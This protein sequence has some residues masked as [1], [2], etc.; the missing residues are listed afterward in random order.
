MV[1]TEAL[2]PSLQPVGGY[3]LGSWMHARGAPAWAGGLLLASLVKYGAGLIPSWS[4]LQALAI[5]W[6]DPLLSPALQPPEDFRLRTP[7]SA[8]LAGWLH[9]TSPAAFL[10]FHFILACV[11]LLLPVLMPVVWRS[12][13][14]RMLVG[15]L[16]LGGA[17]PAVLLTWVGSYDPVS[18]GAA[19]V[20]GLAARRE[21]AAVGWMVFAFNNAP[22]AALG[23][24]VLSAVLL[25][26]RGLRAGISRILWCGGGAVV[27]YV[28]IRT[29]DHH[30]GGGTS[31]FTLVHYYGYSRYV[32]GA[33]HYWPLIVV[34]A[35]GV[36]WLLFTRPAVWR[37]PAVRVFVAL[38]ALASVVVPLLA[39]DETRIT[40]GVLWAPT[41]A[42]AAIVAER[43]PAVELR[44]VL[45]R[46]AP[47][48]LLLVLVVVWDG[49][50]VYKGWIS[51]WHMV[52]YLTGNNPVPSP[53]L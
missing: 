29:L 40:V 5:N 41:L 39:L 8:V 44:R 36:G 49:Q 28:G 31:E 43:V 18:M 26:D 24:L 38:A 35:L 48:A 23:V 33:V 4:L 6:R 21:I 50:L 1:S 22:E 13:D 3:R 12:A 14:L 45:V 52:G 32:N 16:V 27:G 7:V 15:L 51:L 37:V 34:S 25:V 19:A 9:L 30:W 10:S 11:A 53:S 17:V 42:V 2:R 46:C 47:V 20:A